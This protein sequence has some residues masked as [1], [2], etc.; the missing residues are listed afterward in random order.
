MYSSQRRGPLQTVETPVGKLVGAAVGRAVA[1]GLL[2]AP[3]AGTEG[4]AGEA[5]AAETEAVADGADADG[6]ALG[7]EVGSVGRSALLGVTWIGAWPC[8]SV[9]GS[10]ADSGAASAG[11]ELDLDCASITVTPAA[12]PSAAI[13]ATTPISL[14]RGALAPSAWAIV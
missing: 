10:E 12:M 14:L 5:V 3:T 13:T 7:T 11:G 1:S 4:V 2:V 8:A 9:A 6:A